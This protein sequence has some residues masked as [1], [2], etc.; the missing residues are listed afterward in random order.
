MKSKMFSQFLKMPSS[1][2]T[3]CCTLLV[4]AASALYPA[5]HSQYYPRR[6]PSPYGRGDLESLNPFDDSSGYF[7]YFASCVVRIREAEALVRERTSS[8]SSSIAGGVPP[9]PG[10]PSSAPALDLQFSTMQ[11]KLLRDHAEALNSRISLVKNQIV[12]LRRQLTDDLGSVVKYPAGTRQD[13]S[14]REYER[15][16]RALKVAFATKVDNITLQLAKDCRS[17]ETAHTRRMSELATSKDSLK[18]QMNSQVG[19][20]K[21]VSTGT[22]MYVRNYVNF[23]GIDPASQQRLTG[24]AAIELKAS[25][26]KLSSGTGGINHK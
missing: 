21:V 9:G 26:G 24:P 13:G 20:N 14:N 23:G 18:T 17:F 25:P 19:S 1:R 3:I 2:R 6:H 16:I 22:N 11:V 15:T 4:I 8:D 10:G 7:E 5:A 12:F